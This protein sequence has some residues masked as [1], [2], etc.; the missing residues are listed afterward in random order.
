MESVA[1]YVVELRA[2]GEHCAFG[3][4]L[5]D[6]ISRLWHKQSS[7]TMLIAT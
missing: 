5:E 4:T 7:Y 2:I 3:D 1:T 6:M